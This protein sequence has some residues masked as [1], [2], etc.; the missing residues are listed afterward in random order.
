MR[1]RRAYV[2]FLMQKWGMG[3]Q[4]R[5][6]QTCVRKILNQFERWP[7]LLVLRDPRL[8]VMVRADA[9][10]SVWAYFPIHHRRIVARRVQPKTGTRVLLI[11][12]P[13]AFEGDLSLYDERTGLNRAKAL[14]V[15]SGITWGTSYST[16][17]PRRPRM[18]AR[19]PTGN[20]SALR[21]VGNP[22]Y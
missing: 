15:I 9:P 12:K 19:M 14:N 6:I 13:A 22:Q 16:C 18:I 4:S 5:R 1:T 21:L 11:F 20:G 8:E 17:A 10:M 3:E 7:P 2:N